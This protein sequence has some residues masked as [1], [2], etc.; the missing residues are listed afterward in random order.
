MPPTTIDELIQPFLSEPWC[1]QLIRDPTYTLEAPTSRIG[2]PMIDHEFFARTVNAPDCIPGFIGLNKKTT[3]PDGVVEERISL[4]TVDHGIDGYRGVVHG[5]MVAAMIDEAVAGAV[6]TNVNEGGPWGKQKLMT[7]FLN[8]TFIRPAPTPA[9][10]QCRVKL[11]N[12]DGRKAFFTAILQDG[13]GKDL[14]KGEAL[15]VKVQE[16]L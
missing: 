6:E 2:E 4:F 12:Y 1:M 14:A 8:V 7:K 3:R 15:F 13:E 5:G 11:E 10:L 16:K 9:F